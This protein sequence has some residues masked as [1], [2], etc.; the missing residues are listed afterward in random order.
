MCSIYQYIY[1]NRDNVTSSFPKLE[2]QLAIDAL[3][4]MK[5]IKNKISSG[6]IYYL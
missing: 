5:E 4:K 2:S 1:S 3:N 6:K